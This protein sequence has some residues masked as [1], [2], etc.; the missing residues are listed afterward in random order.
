MAELYTCVC[1][2]LYKAEITPVLRKMAT[3][4]HVCWNTSFNSS[5][6]HEC[7]GWFSWVSWGHPSFHCS[8]STIC[9]AF[10]G[11]VSKRNSVVISGDPRSIPPLSIRPSVYLSTSRSIPSIYS[12]FICPSIHLT[13]YPSI[14]LFMYA[15]CPCVYL[16]FTAS[17]KKPSKQAI[18]HS[19]NQ[20]NQWIDQ[21]INQ[22][23][24]QPINQS[25]HQYSVHLL[26]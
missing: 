1:F 7:H 26:Q 6:V 25:I 13:S 8:M 14:Y 20:F 5:A 12:S 3:T 24:N 19:I 18:N 22:P 4:R 17:P 16:L 23:I 21:S 10:L 9:E 2:L 11:L 15:V